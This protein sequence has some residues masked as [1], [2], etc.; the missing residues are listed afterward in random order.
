[1]LEKYW[2]LIEETVPALNKQIADQKA[3][4]EDLEPAHNKE[5]AEH[6]KRMAELEER[7]RELEK[8][9]ARIKEGGIKA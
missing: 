8:E 4:I 1:M 7:I 3:R 6:N 5:I 2:V 9:N